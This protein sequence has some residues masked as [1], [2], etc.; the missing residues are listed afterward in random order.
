MYARTLAEERKIV[1]KKLRKKEKKK[2]TSK[3][4]TQ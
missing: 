2:K 3:T 4:N 1:L